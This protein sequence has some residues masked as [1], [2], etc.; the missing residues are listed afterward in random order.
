MV[1]VVVAVGAVLGHIEAVVDWD[2]IVVWAVPV[3]ARS[4]V[5]DCISSSS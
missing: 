2:V 5:R 3:I 4:L 1:V